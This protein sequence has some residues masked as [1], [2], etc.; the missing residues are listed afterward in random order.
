[1]SE[2][3]VYPGSLPKDAPRGAFTSIQAA[4][5]ASESGDTILVEPGRYKETIVIARDGISLVAVAGPDQTRIVPANASKDTLRISGADDVSVTGF[6]LGGGSN[7]KRQT[8]HIHAADDGHDFAARITLSGNV[9]ERGAGDGIKLSKVSDIVITDNTLTGGGP[10]ESGID[11]VGGERITLSGNTFRAMGHV[12]IS[13]KGGSR[14][15]I[16]ADNLI[17]DVA[18]VGVEIGGYTKLGRYMPGFLEAGHDYEVF[19]VLV[20]G[21]TVTKAGNAAFRVIGGQQ[22]AFVDNTAQGRNA[23][24]KLD[25]S[26]RYHDSW[27]T[28]RIGFSGNSFAARSWLIDRTEGAEIT[29]K[30]KALFEPWDEATPGA[31]NNAAAMEAITGSA[32]ADRLDGSAGADAI[33]GRGGND[34][35]RAGGGD[36]TV[37]GG[38]G[39]DR[40]KGGEGDDS[41]SGGAG[42]DR[43]EGAGGNDTLRGDAGRDRLRGGTG[44]DS[45]SGG[46]ERDRLEGGAG[47]DTLHGEASDDHL[48]GDA[49]ADSLVGGPGD[50]TL[51]GGAGADLFVFFAAD[52]NGA[53]RITDF[54]TTDGDRIALSGFGAGLDGFGDLDSNGNGYLDKGDLAVRLEKDRLTLRLDQR[55]DELDLQIEIDIDGGRMT[56]EH[57]LFTG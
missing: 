21:N 56:T 55:L 26:A 42:R 49:G 14:D 39:H 11:L 30:T 38:N 34:S 53:R 37:Q 3:Q 7:A 16:I 22:V 9:I 4:I 13:V 43:L 47:A 12:G 5:N 8:V 40:I 20:E 45:L 36:D 17:S 46:A 23:V 33:S 2:F 19:N 27:F 54:D 44:D 52:G 15:L 28:D 51:E 32:G 10:T 57:F 41:L 24:V 18:H 25:D 35:I 1:M 31:G 50:D 48:R 29:S 6:T